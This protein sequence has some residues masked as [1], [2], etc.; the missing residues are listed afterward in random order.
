M[1][2]IGDALSLKYST[3]RSIDFR[4]P[5]FQSFNVGETGS[6]HCFFYNFYTTAF[7]YNAVFYTE[8]RSTS[9]GKIMTPF[10]L[11]IAV[12]H[13]TISMELSH[14]VSK[15]ITKCT[16]TT[17]S[18]DITVSFVHLITVPMEISRKSNFIVSGFYLYATQMIN[19]LMND[20]RN[21]FLFHVGF[22]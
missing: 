16:G 2:D 15:Y 3:N 21:Y 6:T 22:C 5:I 1:L 12:I 8:Y 18:T 11:P 10:I 7:D 4:N 17:G 9:V 20:L 19:Q 14:Q 13:I